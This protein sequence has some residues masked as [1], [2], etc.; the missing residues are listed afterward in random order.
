MIMAI[1]IKR[2]GGGGEIEEMERIKCVYVRNRHHLF[3]LPPKSTFGVFFL[4][5]ENVSPFCC[6][7]K[8]RVNRQKFLNEPWCMFRRPGLESEV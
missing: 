3:P 2:G 1:F 7:H 5:F 8:L 6:V 4:E